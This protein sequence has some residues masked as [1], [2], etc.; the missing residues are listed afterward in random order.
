MNY[1]HS[2]SIMHRDLKSHN[3]LVLFG[4]LAFPY[5]LQPKFSSHFS[6]ASLGW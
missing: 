5:F 6:L 2:K 3:L 4:L 1:L